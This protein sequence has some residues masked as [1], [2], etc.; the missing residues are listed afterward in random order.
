MHCSYYGPVGGII[1][2][3]IY[4]GIIKAIKHKTTKSSFFSRSVDCL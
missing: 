3:I 4:E 1:M 2:P